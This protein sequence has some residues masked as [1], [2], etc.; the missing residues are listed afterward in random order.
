MK[1]FKYVFGAMCLLIPLKV[2]ASYNAYITGDDVRIR[3]GAGTGYSVVTA[4]NSNTEVSVI[5]KTLYEG[6]GCSEKWYKVSYNN[7]EGYVCSRYIAF[8]N[9]SYSGIN[10]TDWTARINAN[11]VSI[12][13]STSTS[14]TTLDTLTLGANVTILKSLN[15]NTSGCSGGTWYQVSYYG[16]K[17]GYVCANYVTK[18]SDITDNNIDEEYKEYLKSQDFPESYY[19]Y[20]NYLHKK[21]PNWVFTSGQTNIDFSKAVSSEEGKNYMQTTNDSYRTSS[22]P[23]EGT[24]WFKVNSGVIAFYLD[25]RNFLN[26]N[27]IFMFENLGYDSSLEKDYPSLVKGVFGSGS[28]SDDK[29]V[30]PIVNAG[31]TNKI[32]PIHIASRI[33]QEVGVNGSDSTNGTEFT[34]KGEKYS[35]YY[36]FFN[37]GAYEVTIDGV[38]YSAVTRGLAYAAKLVDRTGNVWDNIETAITEGSSFLANGYITAGQGTLYYQKFNVGPDAYYNSFTNQYMTNIQAPAIEANTTYNSYSQSNNLNNVFV[39]EIPVFNN[40]PSYTSLPSSANTNNDL[41]KLEVEGYS[42]SPIFDE[43]ILSYETYV[44]KNVNKIKINATTKY[45]TSSISGI[46]EKE[47]KDD[48]SIFTIVVKSEAG[49]EKK[50]TIT[51][52]RVEDTTSVKDVIDKVSGN[53]KDD[54]IVNVNYNFKVSDYKNDIIKNGAQSVVIKN[55]NGSIMKDNDILTTSSKITIVTATESKTFT[56]SV[57]GDTSGDGQI[58]IL[59]LLQVQKHLTGSSKLSGEKYYAADTSLDN[60]VTILDLL[61]IQKHIKGDKKI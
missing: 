30:L 17:T 52:H 27:R 32:S 1:K 56:I 11:N 33:K 55:S 9:N 50:Y 15:G 45:D 21:Y 38:K 49:E 36:N 47:L 23:A 44:N 61:Q 34:W 28:L 8:Y 37:I 48:E 16:N 60:S 58:T 54:Y 39:F 19:P 18:K 2:F 25:P 46:G 24:S 4:V 53:I 40:M 35:G 20:L 29:Y 12:R 6:T 59:D 14:S 41:S 7:K 5:D 57:K 3:S 22:T 10:V 26:E 42:L 43:D 51:V 13:K 31:K